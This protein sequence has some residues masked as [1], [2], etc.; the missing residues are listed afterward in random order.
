MLSNF[1]KFSHFFPV[2]GR[3]IVETFRKKAFMPLLVIFVPKPQ[4]FVMS[5]NANPRSKIN[6]SRTAQAKGLVPH[7]GLNLLL[8]SQVSH[9][10]RTGSGPN[11]PVSNSHKW[12][13]CEIW[14]HN[15]P[16]TFGRHGLHHTPIHSD[17]S[18][19]NR[20]T[21]RAAD[22]TFVLRCRNVSSHR[23][24]ICGS[25]AIIFWRRSD[26]WIPAQI[27]EQLSHFLARFQTYNRF[28]FDEL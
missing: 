23:L 19:R 12:T 26:F 15:K 21:G 8:H 14:L 10:A 22:Y 7:F 1:S 16:K 27:L 24:N 9:R 17:H 2:A 3:N 13:G 20:P 6:Q 11:F 5:P 4:V 18:D 28:P 25:S